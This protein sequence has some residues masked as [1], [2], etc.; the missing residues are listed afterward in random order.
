[1]KN[2][3]GKLNVSVPD[4][5]APFRLM[6]AETVKKYLGRLPSD[7]NLPNIMMTAYFAYYKEKICFK[8]ITFKPRQAGATRLIFLK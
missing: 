1:M 7:Y 8:E 4:T 3:K 6:K 5:N 2:I